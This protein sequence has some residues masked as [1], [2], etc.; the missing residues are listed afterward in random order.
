[1]LASIV[2]GPLLRLFSVGL[3]V[4]AFQKTLFSDLRPGGVSIQVMLALAAAA[5][6]AEDRRRVPSPASCSA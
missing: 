4:L 2:Q 6:A 3:V 1:M 5:G